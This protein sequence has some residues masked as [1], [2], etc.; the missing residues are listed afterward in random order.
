MR[1]A[2]GARRSRLAIALPSLLAL[3]VL[4]TAGAPQPASAA[5][6]SCVVD[7]FDAGRIDGDLNGDRRADVVVGL[8]TLSATGPAEAGGVDVHLSGGGRQRV[9]LQELGNFDAGETGAHFGAAVVATEL[10]G[11]ICDDLAVGAPGLDA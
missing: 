7:E 1:H 5:A 8:P 4:G 2:N 3:C 11:D 9:T 10:E 6:P